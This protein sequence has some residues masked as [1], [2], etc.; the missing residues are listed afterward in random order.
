MAT[1]PKQTWRDKL[2]SGQPLNRLEETQADADFNYKHRLREENERKEFE[3]LKSVG[4]IGQPAPVQ[5][6]DSG[7]DQEEKKGKK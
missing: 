6:P 1:A 2:N 5:S 7:D 4:A 3:R